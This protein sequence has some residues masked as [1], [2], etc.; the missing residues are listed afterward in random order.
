[1]GKEAIILRQTEFGAFVLISIG[2]ILYW[3]LLSV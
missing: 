1:M 2:Y 3:A